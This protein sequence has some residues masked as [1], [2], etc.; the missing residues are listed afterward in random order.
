MSDKVIEKI[1]KAIWNDLCDRSGY[2]LGCLDE[3]IQEEIKETWRK[4][5]AKAIS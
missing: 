5:I 4:K 1:I 3:E 2:D